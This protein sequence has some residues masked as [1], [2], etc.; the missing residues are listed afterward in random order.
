MYNSPFFPYFDYC[1]LVWGNCN[2]TLKEKLQKLQNRAAKII[3]GDR[4]DVR[5][6]DILS[7]LGWKSLDERRMNQ[8]QSYVSKALHKKCLEN[9]NEMFKSSKNVK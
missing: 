5:S 9:I 3:T 1:F 2:Q 8:M 7:K 6:K 4:Y